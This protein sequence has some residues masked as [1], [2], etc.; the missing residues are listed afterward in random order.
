MVGYETPSPP[1]P[2]QPS[3]VRMISLKNAFLHVYS[4]KP[5]VLTL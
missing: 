4:G 1:P 3:V 2:I 5:E